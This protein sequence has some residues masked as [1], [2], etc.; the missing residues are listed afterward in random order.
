MSS[1][2]LS[3]AALLALA[4]SAP[5]FAHGS[6][7]GK[8]D[9]ALQDHLRTGAPTQSVIITVK[10]GYRDTLRTALLKHGDRLKSEHPLIESLTVEVHSEDITELANQP[11]VESIASDAVVSAKGGPPQSQMQS[12]LTSV[13][14]SVATPV[15][16]TSLRPTLGLPG[17]P[18]SSSVTGA[19]GVTVA[20]IDSGIAPNDDFEGRITGFYDFTQGGIP[21]T[22]YDDYGHG[23]HVAGLIGSSGK[24]T[25][26]QY[27]G[28]APDVHLVGFKVLDGTGQGKTS[29]VIKAIE[30]I[31]ANQAKLNVQI[32]NLS[33]G[34][35]IYAPAKYDPLVQAVEKATAAGLIVV[36]AAGN[37]GQTQK[38]PASGYTGIT[39][40]GNAPS[41]IT[42][43]AAATQDTVTRDDDVVAPY[44]SRGPTWFDA[45][46]KPDVVAPAHNLA[47]DASTS[48]YLY[49]LL[50][51]NHV[52]A[53]N[54][55]QL[56]ALS[57]SSMATAVTSGVVALMLQAHNQSGYH[58][59]APLTA[60]LVK[61]MLQ[62]SAIK[63]NGGD[64]LTQGAGEI[65]AAGAIALAGAID[66]GAQNWWLGSLVLP[67]S[68]IGNQ[69]YTWSR[70]VIYGANVLG[71]DVLYVNNIAW[72]TNVVWGTQAVW[73]AGVVVDADNIVW[74]A[75]SVW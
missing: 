45:Y 40:P 23:T 14:S 13:R 58:H 54:G 10:P 55:E 65:N 22:P 41:A 6:A 73:G 8:V 42:I 72:S 5:A 52:G 64:V 47:S 37:F 20:I 50:K 15:A 19:T 36:T 18:N 17:V 46:A 44:S 27:A 60:N 57:G 29:D 51:A 38:G 1:G 4:I 68:T 48:S 21:T 70:E 32:I 33:L 66:T 69:V 35:P 56:L 34:H 53:K 74:R 63:L 7:D 39:S 24:L 75:V 59:Q 49:K 43:G 26:Y 31:V 61:G 30:Y 71:G 67:A 28:V 11:W 16:T 62:F 12:W 9:R 25:N 2:R 3:F